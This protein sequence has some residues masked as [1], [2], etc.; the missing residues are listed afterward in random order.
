MSAILNNNFK[1]QWMKRII[2]H[3]PNNLL[4]H[5]FQNNC[6]F[7]FFFQIKNLEKIY[8]FPILLLKKINTDFFVI[9]Q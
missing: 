9:I 8:M 2:I 1:T 6:H 4:S 3:S 7:L 5:L